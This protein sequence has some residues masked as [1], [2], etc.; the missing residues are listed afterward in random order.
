MR[1]G[2]YDSLLT[3]RLRD[4]LAALTNVSAQTHALDEPD[5]PA[6]FARFLADE[7]RRLLGDL[8]GDERIEKQAAI[9]NELL[10]FLKQKAESEST[11]TIAAPPQLLLAIHRTP[12]PPPRPLTPLGTSTL[13]IRPGKPDLGHEL[14]A[15]LASSDRV[16]ALVSFVTWSGFR[17]LRRTLEDHAGAGRKIR[18]LTT[19]YTGATEAAAV[20]AIAKLDNAEVRVSFDGRRSRIH[21]KAWL[22]HRETGFSSVWVGSANLS[23]SA[24]AGGLEW[25]MKVS[26]ADLHH[27][28]ELFRGQFNS[29]WEDPEFEPISPANEEQH[30]RLEQALQKATRWIL[31]RRG[32]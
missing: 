5:A 28:V 2:L 24:L 22:F 14:A 8:H 11:D 15:E 17:R 29:L 19:T 26:E 25:T 31:T 21:A 13:L 16:D 10:A 3:A 7:V 23:A 27:V 12:K 6:R 1:E 18:L 30:A 9:V 4:Q 32:G 20:Q